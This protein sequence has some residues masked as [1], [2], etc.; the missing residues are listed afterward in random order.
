MDVE[1]TRSAETNVLK[2]KGSWTIERANELKCVLLEILNTCEHMTI[3]IE[4]LTELDLSAV[5]LFCSAHRTSLRDG[6]HLALH[7]R[8][9]ETF[10]RMVCD[11]GFVRTIGCHKD[12]GKSCLWT[13][14]DWK[15]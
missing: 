2:L 4:G 7:E 6:K 14:G 5:Q 10:K 8:K 1:M 13:G 12:P 9:S 3:D 11:A 15:S